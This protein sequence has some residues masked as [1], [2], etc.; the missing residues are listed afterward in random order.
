MSKGWRNDNKRI[1]ITLNELLIPPT[2]I[3][4]QMQQRQIKRSVLFL[5]FQ[6]AGMEC[7]KSKMDDF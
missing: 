4:Y 1:I 7:T 3:H 5:L 2:L 6:R